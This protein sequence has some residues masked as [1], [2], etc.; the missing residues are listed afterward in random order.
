[1]VLV[2]KKSI[3]T[4]KLV[5]LWKCITM[6]IRINNPIVLGVILLYLLPSDLKENK[7]ENAHLK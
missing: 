3:G 6:I 1:M 7:K 2:P 5:L 4:K